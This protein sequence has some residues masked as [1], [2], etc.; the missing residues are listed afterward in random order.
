MPLLERAEPLASLA[1]CWAGAC[2]GRG[3][4]ALVEGEAGIGKTALVREFAAG[5]APPA[6][7]L[8]GACD[9]LSTPRP[10]SAL[11]DIAALLSHELSSALAEARPPEDLFALLAASL[12]GV[13]PS[14]LVLEDA[15]WADAATLDLLRYLGRRVHAMRVLLVVTHRDDE[16]GPR[17]PL[18][19]VMGDLASSGELRRIALRP[20]SVAAVAR[21]AAGAGADARLLHQQTGGN[22]FFVTEAIAAGG[23]LPAN[24]RDAVLARAARLDPRARNTLDAAAVIG[25]SASMRLLADVLGSELSLDGCLDA[26]MLRLDA[27]SV[28]FRHEIAR[29]AVLS[30]IPP[31]AL[32][33]WHARVLA[34]LRAR[35]PG[36]VD[37]A[38]L[39]HHAAGALDGA[40]LLQFA[41]AAA[42][43][44]SAMR[45]H[46][47]AAAHYARAL[48]FAREEPPAAR[49]ALLEAYSYECYLTDQS[50]EAIR[51]RTEAARLREELGEGIRCGDDLRWLSRLHWWAANKAEADDSGLR[52]IEVLERFPKGVELAAAY[53]NLSQLRML[54]SNSRA[55]V[56]W[57][58]K[59]LALARRAGDAAVEAHALNNIGTT[60]A[61]G[62]QELGWRLLRRSLELS[63]SH[64]F[65][66][67]AARAYN[68][69]AS[70]A[71][72]YRRLA[73]AERWL[74]EGIAYD[75]DRG[76][77]G[78]LCYLLGWQAILHLLRGRLDAAAAS[79]QRAL[80][81]PRL[82]VILRVNPLCA[83]GRV[84]ALR[85]DADVWPA[86]DE[87]L[88]LA[89]RT[90]EVQR[91]APASV[92]RA[93]AAWLEGDNLRAVAE[94]TR[95]LPLAMQHRDAWYAGE[96]LL[97]IHRAG[98]K[99]RV[100]A[101]CARPCRD[102]LSGRVAAAERA[103]RKL[104]CALEAALALAEQGGEAALRRAFDE[105]EQMG[106]RAAAAS[107]ARKLR[108]IGARSVPRGRRASTR[109]N[110]LGLTAREAEILQL[111]GEG[112]RNAEIGRRLFISP[113]TVEHHVSAILEKLGVQSRTQAA[114]L[115]RRE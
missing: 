19:V 35:S 92:A 94:A 108:D 73:D 86:L 29:Q 22:P 85:G 79:A 27:A 105:L 60:L 51:S 7:V 96:L 10:L 80:A 32:R 30:A 102:Q 44:A 112:L 65:E 2:A 68:N 15:H 58:N 115:A 14:L 75:D 12:S 104:G 113:K 74:E 69:L 6:R 16:V 4:L 107:V 46:R 78:H 31:D 66:D 88:Q 61:G 45:A 103:W 37:L 72:E 54:E 63:L 23:G 62:R 52:A 50:A 95:A 25:A 57:G 17:H 40:A 97:W 64:G 83:L 28:A 59:A 77:H 82:S 48:A 56:R 109:K 55:A 71:V 33:R 111:L 24:V 98:G 49:A 20:L 8:F 43:H 99:A 67:H 90:G 100:P 41:P 18:R 3:M 36:S 1:G 47:E 11:H 76:L 26:G 101:W 38:T 42:R 53:S 81:N 13:R 39:S 34:T 84:R 106:M 70:R 21:L 89:E 91:I 9:A 93:Q 87:A 110:P 114:R 5:M